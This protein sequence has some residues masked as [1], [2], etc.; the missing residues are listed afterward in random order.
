MPH[1]TRLIG[2]LVLGGV[3]SAA[4]FAQGTDGEIDD[5]KALATALQLEKQ[6]VDVVAKVRAA[7]VMIGGG[8]GVLISADGW[9]LTNNHVIGRTRKFKV[10]IPDGRTFDAV[11]TGTDQLG[12]LA[13]LKLQNAKDLPHLAIGDSDTL[14]PGQRVIAVGNPWMAG[15]ADGQ[16]TVSMGVVSAI[17]VFRQNYSDAIQTD[18]P[19]NPGNSGGPLITM[20]GK[21]IG[22]NGQVRVRF[23]TDRV[24]TGAGYAIPA[25]QIKRFLEKMKT[26]GGR[27][28][29]HGQLAGVSLSQAYYD[30]DGVQVQRVAAGSPAEKAGLKAGDRIIAAGGLKASGFYRLLGIVGTYPAGSELPLTVRRGEE[31]H[32]LKVMLSPRRITR[33]PTGGGNPNAPFLGIQIDQDHAGPGVKVAAVIEGGAAKDAGVKPGDVILEADGTKLTGGAR[34][35]VVLIS[36]KKVGDKLRLK[37]QRDLDTLEIEATLRRRGNN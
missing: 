4:S 22:I 16:P 35:L 25:N 28:V 32:S 21:L 15:R 26:A 14:R 6:I 1:L 23:G 3:L 29:G 2:L 27:D 31:E 13:V 12:D 5:A 18:A 9:M 19:I 30:G 20:D 33:A 7:Y 24:N 34:Q 8:S 11:V 37:I 10:R 17:H 36:R